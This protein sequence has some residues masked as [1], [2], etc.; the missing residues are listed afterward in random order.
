MVLGMTGERPWGCLDFKTLACP[1]Q[2]LLSVGV[3][4]LEDAAG[5]AEGA[6]AEHVVIVQVATDLVFGLSASFFITSSF[7][8]NDNFIVFFYKKKRF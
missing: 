3:S 5:Q 6:P 8:C 2:A 4:Q 1:Q 7:C